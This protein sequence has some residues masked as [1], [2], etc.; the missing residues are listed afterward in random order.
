MHD[1]A[2]RECDESRGTRHSERQSAH[3][4]AVFGPSKILMARALEIWAG[5]T[6]PAAPG[7][8]TVAP[9]RFS[10]RIPH[11]GGPWRI[12]ASDPSALLTN[13]SWVAAIIGQR[14]QLNSSGTSVLTPVR[15]SAPAAFSA[16]AARSS[17]GRER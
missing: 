12:S 17:N 3:Y 16:D 4:D 14:S 9:A 1:S 11:A 6:V 13:T 15:V 8:G 2:L 5:T 7:S 10:R